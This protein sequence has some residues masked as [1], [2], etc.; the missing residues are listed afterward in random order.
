MR[1][2]FVALTLA[3]LFAFA[4]NVHAGTLTPAEADS[5]RADID[6]MMASFE[7]GD[8]DALI[9]RTH[10]SLV[11]FAG[12]PEAYAKLVQASLEI[13][14]AT[15]VKILSSRLGTPTETYPAGEE[16]VCFVPRE[17][18]MQ[19]GEM[20]MKSTSFMVAIRTKGASA[21]TYL[22]GAGFRKNPDMLQQLLPALDASVELPSQS[23]EA[24]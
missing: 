17:S 4:A 3:L 14:Q 10:P 21:W 24:M 13:V 1:Q 16:E 18:I 9:R 2:R 22:D 8:A 20:K 15:G 11:K 12:G 6:Q 23:M 7:Q 5:L 19:M